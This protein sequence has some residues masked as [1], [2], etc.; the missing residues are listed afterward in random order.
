VRPAFFGLGGRFNK[1]PTAR[2][3]T[4]GYVINGAKRWIGGASYADVTIIWAR[5]DNGDVGGFLV[6]KGT[7]GLET[8]S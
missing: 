1:S 5:D 8:R 4:S 6:E 3:R 7:P 2:N